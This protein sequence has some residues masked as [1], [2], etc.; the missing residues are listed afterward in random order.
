LGK[1]YTYLRVAAAGASYCFQL[2]CTQN[3]SNS[4]RH[5]EEWFCDSCFTEHQETCEKKPDEFGFLPSSFVKLSGESALSPSTAKR[6]IKTKLRGRKKAKGKQAERRAFSPDEKSVYKTCITIDKLSSSFLSSSPR[7]LLLVLDLDGTLVHAQTARFASG[8][9]EVVEDFRVNY[10]YVYKRPGVDAFLETVMTR[11]KVA[12][13]TAASEPYARAVVAG[14]L[15]PSRQRQLSFLY[16]ACNTTQ[17]YDHDFACTRPVKNLKKVKK[18][19]FLL[20]RV[21]AIDDTWS[22]FKKNYGNGVLV[23]T[24]DDPLDQADDNELQRLLCYVSMLSSHVDVRCVDKR[25]WRSRHFPERKSEG[26]C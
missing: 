5:C 19:G 3:P 7:S 26:P 24:F 21:L 20:S 15:P 10:Y 1:A 11:Y 12:I 2:E 13:W 6:Q 8:T 25:G 16:S 23:T 14:L 9:S 17:Q 18:K 22:T 4:C